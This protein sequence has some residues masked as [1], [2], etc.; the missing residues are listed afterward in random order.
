MFGSNRNLIMMPALIT[1]A[2]TLLRLAGELLHWP[3]LFFGA[4]AGGGVAIVGI[5]WLVPIFGIYFAC[6]LTGGGSPPESR[7]KTMLFALLAVIATVAIFLVFS[8][9]FGEDSLVGSLSGGA[10]GAVAG[11]LIVRQGWP[12]LFSI[13]FCYGLAARIP[14]VVV[15]LLAMLGKWGT[16]YDALPPGLPPNVAA[17]GVFSHWILLGV[18]PQMTFWMG[19]TVVIGTLFGAIAAF[20]CKPKAS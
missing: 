11:L 12:R 20:F 6:K 9:I 2:V 7:G 1:L 10:L 13:L 8:L 18:I 14:V 17:M 3:A 4:E 16:H 19:F 15:M 5:V